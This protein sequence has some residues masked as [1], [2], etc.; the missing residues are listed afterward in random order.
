MRVDP[1]SNRRSPGKRPSHD[2]PP[3][4]VARPASAIRTP[5]KTSQGPID[6]G[7]GQS[8]PPETG[9]AEHPRRA[10]QS[11][12]RL[13]HLR[14]LSGGAWVLLGLSA[15]RAVAAQEVDPSAESAFTTYRSS[16]RVNTQDAAVLADAEPGPR[17]AA[18]ERFTGKA[19]LGFTRTS[20]QRDALWVFS[21]EVSAD[22]RWAPEWSAGLDW[23]FALARHTPETGDSDTRA[24]S[25]NPLLRVAHQ[26]SY[27]DHRRLTVWLGSTLPL[28]RLPEGA[29]RSLGRA[30]LAYAVA[31]RGLW[32]AWQWAPERLGMA[33]GL[34]FHLTLTGRLRLRTETAVGST[35]G[36]G[37]E[38]GINDLFLQV[39]PAME[40]D[41]GIAQLGLRAQGVLMT[42]SDP[43]QISIVPYL[44][45]T[46]GRWTL[47]GR[48]L[49]N[50]DEPLGF[51][52]AG[53]GIWGVLLGVEGSL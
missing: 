51:S 40:V 52:G 12:A 16:S 44:R 24:I 53:L 1:L 11:E 32:N 36:L 13:G 28:A 34:C 38:R 23:G 22:Y 8:L 25:G 47:D 7:I 42:A 19:A 17:D 45:G 43:S 20:G 14:P 49:I 2:N 37:E 35:F 29:E 39:A 18:A 31:T 50:V 9:P 5:T 46:I 6:E 33:G 21:P 15:T 48:V 30:A 41:S 3:A 4:Q 27:S 26:L 10:Q